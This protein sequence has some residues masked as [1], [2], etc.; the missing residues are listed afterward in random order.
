MADDFKIKKGMLGGYTIAYDCPHCSTALKSPLDEAGTVDTCPEC[1][2]PLTVPGAEEKERIRASERQLVQAKE[3]RRQLEERTKRELAKR[4]AEEQERQRLKVRQELLDAP[5]PPSTPSTYDS[6]EWQQQRPAPHATVDHRHRVAGA[7]STGFGMMLGCLTAIVV[8]TFGGCFVLALLVGG[9]SNSRDTGFEG[10]NSSTPL[11]FS[12][13]GPSV[14]QAGFDYKNVSMSSEFGILKVIGEVTN[15][16][17]TSYTLANF[18]VSLYDSNGKLIDTGYVNVSNLA[19][20]Q[21]K[22]FDAIFMGASP[23]QV[24]KYKIQFENGF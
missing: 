16:S 5:S 21:T 1:N 17:S 2:R 12:G 7:F 18:V 24:D 10:S 15:K 3:S 8:G 13:L 19:A 6:P 14:S 22:S 23:N 20:G 11:N 4:K 9:A